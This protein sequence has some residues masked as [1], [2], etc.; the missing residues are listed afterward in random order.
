MLKTA[1]YNYELPQELIAQ[2]PAEPRDTSRMMAL[3]RKSAGI[4]HHNIQD[5]IDHLRKDDLLVFNNT[6]VIPARLFG[7][8]KGTGARIEV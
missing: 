5:I 7:K 2:E 6:R 4:S 3:D 8:K 1:D